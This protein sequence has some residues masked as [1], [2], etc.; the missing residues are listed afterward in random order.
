AVDQRVA[1]CDKRDD[2]AVSNPD[3]QDL[4]N[5]FVP[6]HLSGE[7]GPN[8]GALQPEPQVAKEGRPFSARPSL[9]DLRID[10]YCGAASVTAFASSN[11]P[12][13]TCRPLMAVN[14]VS[15]VSVKLHVPSAPLKFLVA[16]IASRIA[17]LSALPARV[18]ASRATF[19]DS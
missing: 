17:A 4:K 11:L 7:S 12:P 8:D 6:L 9:A 3:Q 18:I 16:K 10:R 2:R 19:I 13:L 1:E 15:P 5:L 14:V